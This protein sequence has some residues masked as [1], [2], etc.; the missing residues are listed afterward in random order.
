MKILLL[1]SPSCSQ[2]FLPEHWEHDQ[3]ISTHCKRG[4]ILKYFQVRTARPIGQSF[5]GRLLPL[6]S[7]SLGNH[8]YW[9]VCIWQLLLLVSLSL[10]SYSHWSVCLW[11]TTP[12]G[13]SVFEQLLILVS[14]SLGNHSYW[15]VCLWTATHIGQSVF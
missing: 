15:S 9:S 12:I 2:L 6:V 10:N 13:Q 5:F 7:L 4:K 14:L 11:A 1:I 8:S 3:H